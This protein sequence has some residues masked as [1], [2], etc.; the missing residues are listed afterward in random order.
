MLSVKFLTIFFWTET[1]PSLIDNKP[2]EEK[3]HKFNS[4]HE[5][6]MYVMASVQHDNI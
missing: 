2:C 4:K 5:F 1:R 6:K 3:G